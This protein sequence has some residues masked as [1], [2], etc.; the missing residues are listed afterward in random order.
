MPEIEL[1][2]H[3]TKISEMVYGRE[4]HPVVHGR[5]LK[6]FF[7]VRYCRFCKN[8]IKAKYLASAKHGYTL[9]SNQSHNQSIYCDQACLLAAKEQRAKTVKPKKP[10]IKTKK[11][12]YPATKPSPQQ[13]QKIA[14]YIAS[15]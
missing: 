2:K 9:I 14:R 7:K 3:D 8:M 12:G 6:R 10:H 11:S 5:I 1:Q 13:Q 4:S 15:L